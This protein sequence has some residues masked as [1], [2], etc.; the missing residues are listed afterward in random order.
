MLNYKY[1]KILNAWK[2]YTAAIK[3]ML[4]IESV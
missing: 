4:R 1:T 3:D 2:N